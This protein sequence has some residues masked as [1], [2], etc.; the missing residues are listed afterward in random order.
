MTDPSGF[1]QITAGSGTNSVA[2]MIY[3]NKATPVTTYSQSA[4][5][6]NY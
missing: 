5:T 4:A 1:N 2:T 6:S 3:V